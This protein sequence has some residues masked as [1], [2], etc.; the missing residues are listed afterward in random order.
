MIGLALITIIIVAALIAP[1]IFDYDTQVIMQ[2]IP[3]RL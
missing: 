3:E 2:N 1:F